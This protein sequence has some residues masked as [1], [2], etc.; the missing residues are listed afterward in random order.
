MI[1]TGTDAL[2]VMSKLGRRIKKRLREVIIDVTLLLS[3]VDEQPIGSHPY[4]TGGAEAPWSEKKSPF[5]AWSRR[6]SNGLPSKK[7]SSIDALPVSLG[8]VRKSDS[9]DVEHDLLASKQIHYHTK[10][11][12]TSSS[13]ME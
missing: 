6:S 7:S 2:H 8:P 13:V 10:V 3:L 4:Q 1:A 5:T 12:S 11:D 9:V